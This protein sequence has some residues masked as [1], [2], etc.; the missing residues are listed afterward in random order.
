MTDPCLLPATAQL[1]LLAARELSAVELLDAHL[2]RIARLNPLLNA[3]VGL[4]AA[5]ARAMAQASDARRAR[6]EAGALDG[7][8]ISV[9]DAFDVAGFVSTAGAKAYAD[10]VP[11]E[12]AAAVARLRAA[13]AV[14]LGKSLVPTFSGD[15]QSFNPVHGVANNPWDAD[16]SPGGSSGGAAA[17]VAT[18]MSAF[19]L[20]S[21]LGSSIRW[22]AAACGV[23]GLKTTWSLVSSWGMVPPP[24][25][26]RTARNPDL[27]VAGPIAR[28]PDDI[29]LVLGV[30]AGGREPGS[31]APVVLAPPRKWQAEGL[32][33]AVWADDPF[34][35]ADRTVRDAARRAGRLLEAQGAVVEE[36]ARPG[37]SYEEAYE[38]FALLNHAI[39]AYGLPPKVRARIQSL[40]A[41]FAPGDLSHRALQARG[42]R[43]TPGFYQQVQ[44]RRMAVKKQWARFFERFDAVI[45]P[46]APVAALKHDHEPDLFARTLDVDGAARPYLDFSCGPRWR[47]AATCRRSRSP[48]AVG[49]RAAGRRAG[50]RRAWR[51]PAGHRHRAH[52]GRAHR[53]LARAAAGRLTPLTSCRTSG[54]RRRRGPA[55]CSR[56]R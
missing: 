10:R 29:E 32:R 19:E 35:K 2:A 9:K 55:R 52:A 43:M 34:A 5:R 36:T 37:F 7:L 14:I 51:R 48:W 16:F 21:D 30:I 6:G 13:G 12:D 44:A 39:V 20:G 56:G 27:V 17:A 40:A 31:P 25:E 24:P 46:A 18:G 3:V 4:D 47:A 45:A 42:A 15:F 8:P 49:R 28:T 33:V 23:Y 11:E 53:R 1:A 50:H 38:V 54:R 22:P 26:R 41:Q